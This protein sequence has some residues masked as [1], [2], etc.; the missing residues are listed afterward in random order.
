MSCPISNKSHAIKY[1]I[2][3][4]S[5]YYNVDLK[6]MT[7][8][9]AIFNSI[10]GRS[11]LISQW[12]GE[13]KLHEMWFHSGQWNEGIERHHLTIGWEHIAY[14]LRVTKV[15]CGLKWLFL[16]SFDGGC[17]LTWLLQL[18]WTVF[19][20]LKFSTFSLFELS[21]HGNRV[22]WSILQYKCWR[23]E[24]TFSQNAGTSAQKELKI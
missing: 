3:Y 16:D 5:H 17:R 13:W 4:K 8:F 15:Y 10:K 6:Y 14:K 11:G 21:L 7:V 19:S 9:K 22:E 2:S 24:H 20:L 12:T 23:P 18:I 1:Y